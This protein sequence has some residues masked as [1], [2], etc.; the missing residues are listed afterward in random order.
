MQPVGRPDLFHTIAQY[1]LQELSTMQ[2]TPEFFDRLAAKGRHGIKT[3]AGFCEYEAG[4]R[5]EILRKGDL[6]FLRQLKL[7]REVQQDS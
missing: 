4:A 7:I 6:C 5:D 2:T 3:G 1:L